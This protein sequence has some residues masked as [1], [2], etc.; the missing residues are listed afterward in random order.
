MTEQIYLLL[1]LLFVIILLSKFVVRMIKSD[2]LKYR[3]PIF[4]GRILLGFLVA[5]LF[6]IVYLMLTGEDVI[7]KF[8]G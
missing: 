2:N 1:I 3:I 5:M 6:Y 7:S 4:Y 8:L